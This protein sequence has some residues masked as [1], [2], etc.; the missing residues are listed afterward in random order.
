MK[1]KTAKFG[2]VW[3]F[4]AVPENYDILDEVPERLAKR[5]IGD[6]W[7]VTHF[8][9]QMRIGELVLLWRSG[10]TAGIYGTAQI[11]TVPDRVGGKTRV[12]LRFFPLLEQPVLK[13]TLLKDPLL[14]NLSILRS[15]RGT[16]F[17]VTPEEWEKLKHLVGA[18]RSDGTAEV[19]D[20]E[21]RTKPY[22]PKNHRD[23]RK[24]TMASIVQR[25]GQPEFRRQLMQ[26]FQ[27]RCLISNCDAGAVLEAA[28]I[29]PYRGDHTNNPT[30]GLLL[31]ADLHTLFDLYL[32]S[33]DAR[34]RR[35]LIAP[36]LE[37]TCYAGL[38]NNVIDLPKGGPSQKALEK[39]RAE[40]VRRIHK[41]NPIP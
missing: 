10:L 4:Q 31:R 37:G 5:R 2:D 27:S 15:A 17:E 20:V 21:R 40:F 28:H 9:S 13:S 35:V 12:D 19:A 30:N 11:E 1:N 14:K 34:K 25:R 8:A 23:G 3:I 6:D 29:C 38:K 33:I 26:I 22:D 39:H 32:I 7:Q 16:N 24:R 36:T 41:K 18:T